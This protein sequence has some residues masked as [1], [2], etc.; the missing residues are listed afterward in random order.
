MFLVGE[1]EGA[2]LEADDGGK[3]IPL[4]IARSRAK[5]KFETEDGKTVCH[6]RLRLYGELLG[7]ANTDAFTEEGAK[8][9]ENLFTEII[10][11]KVENTIKIAQEKETA[12][13][14][15]LAVRL[16]QKNLDDSGN[17]W[18]EVTISIEPSLKIRD[19]G[20]IR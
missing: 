5:Y 8:E 20:R 2:V 3:K 15:G 16:R 9:M 19:T 6:I 18:E 14:L 1:A 7:S 12:E 10:K 17:F 4:R 11:E 13:F